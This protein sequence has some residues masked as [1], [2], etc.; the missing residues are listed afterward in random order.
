MLYYDRQT[1]RLN[2]LNNTGNAWTPGVLGSSGSLQNSQ[3]SVALGGSSVS[4]SGAMLTLNLAMTFR[5]N[6][7]GTKHVYL[8][9]ANTSGGNSGWQDR[10]DWTVPGSSSSTAT[11]GGVSAISATPSSGS[12]TTRTFSLQYGDSSGAYS[13][14]MTWVWLTPAFGTNASNS[15]M[16][17]FEREENTLYLLNDGGTG[18]TA[19][20]L[21]SGSVLANRQCSITLNSSSVSVSGTTLTLNL[22]MSFASGFAGDKDIYMFASNASGANS[23]WQQRGSWLVP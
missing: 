14:A 9:A 20:V 18:W 8:Y 3:C 22:A 6:Y 2:L 21:G 15:C 11:L 5:S 1:G 23:G 19:G 16:V 10:G 4:L 12:G 13:L 17:Y 7:G